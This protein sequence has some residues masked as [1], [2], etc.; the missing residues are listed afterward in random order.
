VSHFVRFSV[1]CE[2]SL[3]F[4]HAPAST[5]TSSRLLLKFG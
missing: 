2:S 5:F 3:E 1:R 4:R